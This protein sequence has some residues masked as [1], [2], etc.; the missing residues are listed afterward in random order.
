MCV[1]ERGG[2]LLR[3]GRE[4]AARPLLSFSFFSSTSPSFP[5]FPHPSTSSLSPLLSPPPGRDTPSVAA[6][7]Q[8][9]A[10]PGFHKVFFGKTEVALPVYGSTAA[11]AAS[12]PGADVF[13]SLA[14]FRSAA[15]SA[16][17]ALGVPTIRTVAVIA[18]GVPEADT[19]ALI[20]AA[21]A[22][23]KTLIGPA[24]VGAVA[25]GRF[26]IGDAGGTVDNLVASCLHRP[27][28]V[29]CV[30]K[31][32]GMS[33][34]LYAVL[35]RS[36]DGL[37]EGVAIGG[38]AFPGSSLSSHALRYEADPQVQVRG[39]KGGEKGE[40]R[41]RREGER[42]RCARVCAQAW[43]R[44]REKKHSLSLSHF[45]VPTSPFSSLSIFI[46]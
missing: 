36:T 37:A 18:E 44:E 7:V 2:G 6:I 34:E 45:P 16:A 26:R 30:A 8:P 13:I 21:A 31:S 5:S 17:D 41:G 33:N 39:E 22:S 3:E 1:R 19:K 20:A 24:T 9:G 4:G 43:G 10:P 38:D 40:E 32:G 28:S 15:A 27:G 25:A 14:S 11:A 23:G 46:R 12:H 42:R 29:G 35:A